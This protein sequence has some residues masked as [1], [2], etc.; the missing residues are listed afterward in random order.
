M[1]GAPDKEYG[2]NKPPPTGRVQERSKG[3]IV[4]PSTSQ[5]PSR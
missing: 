4:C 2:I 5:N 3:D 1:T